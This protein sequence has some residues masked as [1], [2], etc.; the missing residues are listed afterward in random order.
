MMPIQILGALFLAI[1]L[2]HVLT[3]WR[4]RS[5]NARELIFWVL[6]FGGILVVLLLPGVSIKVARLLGVRR[7]T[8]IVV[9]GSVGLLYY[10]VFRIYVRIENIQHHLTLVLRELALT[11]SAL[12]PS[13]SNPEAEA[14]DTSDGDNG[15]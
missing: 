4:S 15:I 3:R 7:G 5:L 10:L 8:D 9:Y 2:V 14:K 12:S 1:A 6:V 11:E 13:A